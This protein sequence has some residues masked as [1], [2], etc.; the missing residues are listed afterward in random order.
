[1][2][3]MDCIT[4]SAWLALSTRIQDFEP[5]PAASRARLVPGFSNVT[6]CGRLSG[7]ALRNGGPH[8]LRWQPMAKGTWQWKSTAGAGLQVRCADRRTALR[9]RE[10]RQLQAFSGDRYPSLTI[11]CPAGSPRLVGSQDAEAVPVT[12]HQDFLVGPLKL[13]QNPPSYRT[14]DA[15]TS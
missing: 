4:T 2:P 3:A 5:L 11:K 9:R 13:I 1:M 6:C 10:N 8:C 12:S 7:P 14:A 15:I